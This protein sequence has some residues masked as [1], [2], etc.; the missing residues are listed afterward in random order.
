MKVS[1]ST[2][3]IIH[4]TL[5]IQTLTIARV[6]ST[7]AFTFPTCMHIPCAY[8]RRELTANEGDGKRM[9]SIRQGRQSGT[10]VSG[11][12]TKR[13][14]HFW[15]PMPP[16]PT[17]VTDKRHA[18]YA[19]RYACAPA[20]HGERG[21]AFSRGRVLCVLRMLDSET[22]RKKKRRLA[23]WGERVCVWFDV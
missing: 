9:S 18:V 23:E 16:S 22:C 3:Y 11:H 4:H 14:R 6:E 2:S 15:N 1:P 5:F 17:D 8:R 20:R 12:V 21:G 10:A 13:R 19:C 7:Y